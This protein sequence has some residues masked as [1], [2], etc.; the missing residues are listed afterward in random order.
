MADAQ[1]VDGRHARRDTNRDRIVKAFL[2]L[3]RAGV[4]EPGAH[5]IAH[6][7]GVS[8]RTV[9]RCFEDMEALYC[10][11]TAKVRD[12]FL[13]RARLDL[14]TT[15]RAERLERL[16]KNRISIFADI[17]PFRFAAEPYRHRYAGVAEDMRLLVQVERERLVLV[18]NPDGALDRDYFEA[19]QAVTSFDYWRRL[20]IDQALPRTKAGH[21][22]S[23][24]ARAVY[25]SAP[26]PGAVRDGGGVR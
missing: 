17:E 24:A 25:R 14:N 7:A 1:P 4:S 12:E 26:D 13:P 19:L 3:V 18:I 6:K 16:L 20:R 11:L 2:E 21:V 22:M 9:F 15:D 23:I 8:P 5:T 10:E